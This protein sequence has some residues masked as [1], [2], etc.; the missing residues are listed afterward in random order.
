MRFLNYL[1]NRGHE[2]SWYDPKVLAIEY[3]NSSM[4]DYRA[5]NWIIGNW[6]DEFLTID[7]SSFKGAL[8]SLSRTDVARGYTIIN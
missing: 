4:L 1:R 2:T 5:D 7:F 6:T 8:V 3:Q